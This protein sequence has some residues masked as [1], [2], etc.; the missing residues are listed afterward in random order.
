MERDT[1]KRTIK[2]ELERISGPGFAWSVVDGDATN[3]EIFLDDETTAVD[4]FSIEPFD[5]A[6]GMLADLLPSVPDGT[7]FGEEGEHGTLVDFL[8]NCTTRK[9]AVAYL[10]RFVWRA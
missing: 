7:R 2:R 5:V 9:D 10:D 3:V 4:P 8:C 1:T 6:A